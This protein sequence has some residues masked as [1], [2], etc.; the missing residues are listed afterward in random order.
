MKAVDLVPDVD[1]ASVAAAAMVGR[2]A[3]EELGVHLSAAWAAAYRSR[4][5]QSVLLEFDSDGARF[6]FDLANEAGAAC[7][8]RP[9]TDPLVT[10]EN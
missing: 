8:R 5:P 7:Q 4:I 2:G 10:V 3:S 9:K 1:D 6:L